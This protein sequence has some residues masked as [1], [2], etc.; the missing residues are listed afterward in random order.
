MTYQHIDA[1]AT[2]GALGAEI[3]GV[4]L[5]QPLG[6]PVLD[7]LHQALLDHLVIFFRNQTMTP[8]ELAAFG[9][10]FGELEEEPFIPRSQDNPG[11]HVMKGFD[12]D[13]PVARTLNWHVDHTYREI[14]TMGIVLHGIDVPEAGNDTLFANMYLA[15]EA[16]APEM[17]EFLSK[18]TAIH[19]VCQYGLNSGIESIATEDAI[20]RLAI[21]R[22]HFPQ[23]EHPLICTHPETGRK[24]LYYNPAWVSGIKGFSKLESEA[25]R[26]LL[27]EH[28]A[29]PIFQCRFRWH[30][31]SVAFWD[32]RAV[33][34]SPVPDYFGKRNMQRVAIGC[35]WHPS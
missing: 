17:K 14:P 34:H 10:Q 5:S 18:L 22:K 13:K 2:T 25:I 1:Q 12:P 16:L 31:G 21:M 19:D 6:K 15:Y 9:K 24:M 3:S 26:K 29:Q 20:E 32:N 27:S 8:G 30:N 11:V 33:Q 4:D 28:T 23:V 35:D 7:E